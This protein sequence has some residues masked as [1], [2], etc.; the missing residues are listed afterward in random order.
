M[1]PNVDGKYY[2][3]QFMAGF[4]SQG[5]TSDGRLKPDITAPGS[6]PPP[7]SCP[8]LIWSVGWF[9]NAAQAIGGAENGHCEVQHMRG[10]SMATPT[11]AGNAVLIKQYFQDGWY[12]SGSRNPVDSFVPSGALLKAMLIQSGVSMDYVTYDN[13]NGLYQQSTGG[14]PSNIQ[15]FGKVRLSNILNFGPSSASPITLFV[16]GAA[17]TSSPYYASIDTASQVDTYLFLTSSASTQPQIRVTLAFTDEIGAVGSSVTLVNNL[18]INVTE[19]GTS[20][21]YAPY[22]EE[23]L[24]LNN[25]VMVDIPTPL[26]NTNYTVT[27]TARVLNSAQP[28][29]LGTS[30]SPLSLPSPLP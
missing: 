3:E 14:Y 29:A 26:S 28:Y 13:D 16:R 11:V 10:T 17:E 4:S 18:V 12:P 5:P 30:S 6:C 21:T 2:S 22:L 8:P 24:G 1:G 7:P 15:G 27:V 20:R 9:I 25:V 19:G 23:D